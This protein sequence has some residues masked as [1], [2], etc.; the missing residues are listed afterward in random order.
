MTCQI[1][2]QSLKDH[3]LEFFS[4]CPSSHKS[5]PILLSFNSAM[6]VRNVSYET[7]KTFRCNFEMVE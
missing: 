7:I 5:R 1:I 2:K 3:L 4:R 6:F